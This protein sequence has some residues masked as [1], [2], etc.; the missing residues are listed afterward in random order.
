MF[1]RNQ[2]EPIKDLR[3]LIR[4]YAPIAKNA[5]TMLINLSDDGEVV[6]NLMED[7]AFLES[8]L[9]RVT[10]KSRG[11]DTNDSQC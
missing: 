8:L 9:L 10:V 6:R 11:L 4:D 3:L 5:L 7:E 2:L 1:K